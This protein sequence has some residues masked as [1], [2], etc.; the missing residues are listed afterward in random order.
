MAKDLTATLVAK[1]R[2]AN[3]AVQGD[4]IEVKFSDPPDEATDVEIVIRQQ[5]PDQHVVTFTGSI[6][7]GK[8]VGKMA[9][10]HVK[11]SPN[12]SRPDDMPA[13][14][15]VGSSKIT[16]F[17]NDPTA[18]VFSHKLSVSVTGKI[19]GAN[20]GFN[21]KS[22]LHLFYK[23]VM[24]V[25]SGAAKDPALTVI[26]K[27]AAQWRDKQKEVRSIVTIATIQPALHALSPKDYNPLIAAITAAAKAAPHGIVAL[28]VGHGDG[29]GG[30]NSA[31]CDLAAEDGKISETEY[32]RGLDIDEVEML[33]GDPPPPENGVKVTPGDRTK[34]KLN[35]L[36]RM[37]DVFAKTPIRTL[38]LHTC[39]AGA[40]AAFIQRIANRTRV[41]VRAHTQQI[42]YTGNVKGSIQ[43][44]YVGVTPGPSAKDEWPIASVTSEFVPSAT[45]APKHAL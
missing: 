6:K 38:L 42:E 18:F 19:A 25:P 5:T 26:P 43:A 3:T 31:W 45:P 27:W 17:M 23:R 16:S 35:A 24:I 13:T 28:C 37:A 41:F 10:G 15:T 30:G 4:T 12:A 36:D 14:F 29:G 44:S 21:G 1:G 20:S 32:S 33:E 22:L 40:N 8:W 39:S 2:A 11:V 34:V 7:G 9:M